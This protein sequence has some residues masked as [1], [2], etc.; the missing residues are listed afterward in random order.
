MIFN[1][2]QLKYQLFYNVQF[3]T[4]KYGLKWQRYVV[5]MLQITMFP[6]VK[7]MGSKT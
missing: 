3:K 7:E 2:K 1:L 6:N 4:I 5:L